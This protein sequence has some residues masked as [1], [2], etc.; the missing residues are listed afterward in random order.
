MRHEEALGH[1]SA[2]GL[3]WQNRRP[4]VLQAGLLWAWFDLVN[5]SMVWPSPRDHTPPSTVVSSANP[6]LTFAQEVEELGR[7]KGEGP[8]SA[9]E[10]LLF[11]APNSGSGIS[12]ENNLT[13][14]S[15]NQGKKVTGDTPASSHCARH[16]IWLTRDS[17]FPL[18]KLK[19]H[20][21][22]GALVPS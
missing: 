19:R 3:K 6:A 14:R 18:D 21:V 11:L 9:L 12:S 15:E 17:C 13:G 7:S 4:D 2:C 5:F 20:P 16:Y 10:H 8:N 1:S 22:K